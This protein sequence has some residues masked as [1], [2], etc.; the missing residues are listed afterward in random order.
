MKKLILLLLLSLSTIIIVGCEP[1]NIEMES[2]KYLGYE[3]TGRNINLFFEI[4]DNKFILRGSFRN[5]QLLSVDSTYDITYSDDH[6]L[7]NFKVHTKKDD[8]K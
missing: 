3:N 8:E 1:D 7:L 5:T 4:D 6:R 2:V